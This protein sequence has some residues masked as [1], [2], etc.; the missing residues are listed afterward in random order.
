MSARTEKRFQA[1]RRRQK[2]VTA[3]AVRGKMGGEHLE[4]SP[5]G[6]VANPCGGE[7]ALVAGAL[8]GPE[9]LLSLLPVNNH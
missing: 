7:N 4:C 9:V 1:V 2:P 6:K 3:H 5:C 8:A